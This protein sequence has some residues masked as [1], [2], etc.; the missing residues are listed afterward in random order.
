VA[1]AVA[2]AAAP[3]SVPS[4]AVSW[5]AW[6]CWLSSLSLSFSSSAGTSGRIKP[7]GT[8]RLTSSLPSLPRASPLNQCRPNGPV[9]RYVLSY[10][11]PHSV[12]KNSM[13]D[14]TKEPYH[15]Q[16]A[17][18][19]SPPLSSPTGTAPSYLGHQ[20]QAYAPV[21]PQATGP[22][23]AGYPHSQPGSPP[24]A[25]M[26]YTGSSVPGQPG[27]GMGQ[28]QSQTVAY[29]AG[30]DEVGASGRRGNHHHGQMNELS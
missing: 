13:T 12:E 27:Q 4:S 23:S 29:E 14:K 24:P 22:S 20:S 10:L 8:I 9:K 28:G 16:Q 21:S 11:Y 26:L 17:A 25:D 18:A 6:P 1:V 19:Y 5:A 15:H 7:V 30:G 3:T 2:A